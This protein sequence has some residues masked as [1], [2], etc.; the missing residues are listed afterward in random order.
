VGHRYDWRGGRFVHA[1]TLPHDMPKPSLAMTGEERTA[2][3]TM[4]NTGG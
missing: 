3:D 1:D 4:Y 2:R